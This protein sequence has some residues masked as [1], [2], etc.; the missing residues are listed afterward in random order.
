MDAVNSVFT[1]LT[2]KVASMTA[3]REF[4]KLCTPHIFGVLRVDVDA[5]AERGLEIVIIHLPCYD[6]GVGALKVGLVH[7]ITGVGY[8]ELADV[9]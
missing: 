5:L 4:S 7:H 8:E 2:F 6:L 9:R 1:F 3:L